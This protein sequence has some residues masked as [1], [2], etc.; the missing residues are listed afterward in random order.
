METS[1]LHLAD[2]KITSDIFGG[3]IHLQS[4]GLHVWHL[5]IINHVDIIVV[6]EGL[7]HTD[8]VVTYCIIVVIFLFLFINFV[9]SWGFLCLLVLSYHCVIWTNGSMFLHLC[10]SLFPLS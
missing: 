5:Y 9:L 10:H 8:R 2:V 4:S 3:I 6:I 7:V 1:G